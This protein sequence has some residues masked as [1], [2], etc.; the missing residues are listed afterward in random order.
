M[1]QSGSKRFD[2]CRKCINFSPAG[3][4]GSG[5]HGSE[6]PHHIHGRVQC[7]HLLHVLPAHRVLFPVLEAE[8]QRADS[9]ARASHTHGL[10]SDS[11]FW[12]LDSDSDWIGLRTHLP[13]IC[14]HLPSSAVIC[15]QAAETCSFSSG[16]SGAHPTWEAEIRL[17]T[18][19]RAGSRPGLSR[20]PWELYNKKRHKPIIQYS[21]AAHPAES[22]GLLFCVGS[23][24]TNNHQLGWWR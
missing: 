19:R 5:L 23:L 16:F 14:Y 3:G 21:T 12:I 4:C 1:V 17:P 8:H 20:N 2:F 22:D 15:C 7:L 24:E 6:F 11:G 13:S 18:P 9:P 10:D